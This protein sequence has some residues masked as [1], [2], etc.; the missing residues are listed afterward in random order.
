M[1]IK[2]LKICQRYFRKESISRTRRS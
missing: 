2:Q 1:N